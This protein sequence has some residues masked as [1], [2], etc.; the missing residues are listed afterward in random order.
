M[1]PQ[2]LEIGMLLKERGQT[3]AASAASAWHRAALHF[4][5]S[6]PRASRLTADNLVEA[7]GLPNESATNRNNC[8]GSVFTAAHKAGLLERDGY[9]P[10]TR[11][12]SHGRV[13]ALWVRK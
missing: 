4:I 10:S 9:R 2:Q 11:P 6:L 12:E 5:A 1:T 8:V 13:I 3:R 7:L